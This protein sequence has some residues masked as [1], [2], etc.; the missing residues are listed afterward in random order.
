MMMADQK[1]KV[2]GGW[3]GP[4]IWCVSIFVF[5]VFVS[6]VLPMIA[7]PEAAEMVGRAAVYGAVAAFLVVQLVKG[8]KRLKA[9][10]T[11]AVKS[12]K[13]KSNSL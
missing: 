4:V 5:G 12:A 7:S 10:A 1:Q 3:R 2:I 8:L 13:A 9:S 11:E 6:F